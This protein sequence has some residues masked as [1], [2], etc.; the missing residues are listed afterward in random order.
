M[1]HAGKSLSL[2]APIGTCREMAVEAE[3]LAADA[4]PAR[5]EKYLD[6]ARQWTELADKM[7]AALAA[8]DRDVSR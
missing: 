7:E 5:R 3:R 6:L 4:P 8:E 2:S 1:R